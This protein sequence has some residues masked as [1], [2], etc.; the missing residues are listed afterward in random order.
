MKSPE[1]RSS[2]FYSEKSMGWTDVDLEIVFQ[3]L[4]EPVNFHSA[5]EVRKFF[6]FHISQLLF[7]SLAEHVSRLVYLL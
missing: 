4:F 7:S 2:L 3:Y 5:E 1:I 6:K